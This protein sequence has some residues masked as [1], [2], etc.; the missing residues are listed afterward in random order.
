MAVAAVDRPALERVLAD[1]TFELIPL[2]N[3]REQAAALPRG[4]TVSVTA[5]P[6]KGIEATVELTIALERAGLHAIPHLSARMIRDRAHL[7]ELLTRLADAGIDRAFVVGGD[8]DEPGE[9]L[10]GLSLLRAVAD[11][12][13]KPA[14][15][16]VP[17]Y[18]QGHPDIPDD[19]LLQA[20]RDKAPL[21]QYM[22]TQLCFDP[23]AI[24]TFIAARR[25]EGIT[26]PVKIGLPG[27]AEIP[28]L[29]SISARIGVKDASK[30]VLKNARFVGAILR[31]GG[32][33]RPT[34]LVEK[35]APLIADPDADIF[36][37]HVYTFN[38]VPATVEWR[39]RQRAQNADSSR[40]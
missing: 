35:L 4:A 11:L 27:V 28:K 10:D 12:G 39:N 26:L 22:T 23:K 9:F 31:S 3:A 24:A 38:N 20:L 34:N 36:G 14:E 40:D 7:A 37:F 21:V 8:A 17:C 19:A 32:I 25:A 1:P 5:S 15:V 13:Q 18:P 16:G 29:L 30:F 2:K 6:G 33:Y